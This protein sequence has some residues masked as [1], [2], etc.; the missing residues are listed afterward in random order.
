MLFRHTFNKTTLVI[1][2]HFSEN[3]SPDFVGGILGR[4]EEAKMEKMNDESLNSLNNSSFYK[5][6]EDKNNDFVNKL[7]ALP[8]EE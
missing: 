5:R 2:K 8:V 6:K 1:K 7:F 4:D 3:N